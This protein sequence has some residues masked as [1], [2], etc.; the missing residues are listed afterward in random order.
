MGAAWDAWRGLYPVID[1]GRAT[2]CAD[3]A[4]PVL[5]LLGAVLLLPCHP[6]TGLLLLLLLDEVPLL[7][8]TPLCRLLRV[9]LGFCLALLDSSEFQS[10]LVIW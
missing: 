10:L 7:V 1:V 3:K 2:A 4:L 6:L 8:Q 5:S 9:C